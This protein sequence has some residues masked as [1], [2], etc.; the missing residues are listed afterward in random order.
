[1]IERMM[2]KSSASSVP[3]IGGFDSGCGHGLYCLMSGGLSRKM[4]HYRFFINFSNMIEYIYLFS[5]AS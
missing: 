5:G 4:G 2:A 1:M 3:L